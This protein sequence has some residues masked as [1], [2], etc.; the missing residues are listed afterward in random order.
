MTDPHA[1][2]PLANRLRGTRDAV[3]KFR[4]SRADLLS[5]FLGA[6]SGI[7]PGLLL[8]GLHRDAV[9][10][11]GLFVSIPVSIGTIML[12]R[13]LDNRSDTVRTGFWI[14]AVGVVALTAGGLGVV[15]TQAT[16]KG[17][18]GAYLVVLMF[19]IAVAT[20][21]VVVGCRAINRRRGRINP[22]KS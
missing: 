10:L 16:G 18:I 7:A 19:I 12:L 17:L 4:R 3:P 1:T 11:N 9:F 22:S 2:E 20:A 14:A 5:L 21:G 13:R 6:V 15:W 8:A